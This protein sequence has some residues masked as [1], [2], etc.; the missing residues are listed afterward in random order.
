MPHTSDQEAQPAEPEP[1]VILRNMTAERYFTLSASNQ[2]QNLIDGLLYASPAPTE[3]HEDLVLALAEALDAFARANGGKVFVNRPCWLGPGTVIEPDVAYVVRD[4]LRI[5]GRYLREAPDL[6]VEVLSP[7][8][9]RFDTEAKFAAYGA[10]GVREAWFV[11]PEAKTVTVVQ[12]NGQAWQREQAVAFGGA[13]PSEV[14]M[15]IGATGL[16]MDGPA[17]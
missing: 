5:A 4:R 2:S 10:C 6:T 13:I 8:T 1:I 3:A 14:V 17:S 9:R 7:G 12:G 15:G 16:T 11:D